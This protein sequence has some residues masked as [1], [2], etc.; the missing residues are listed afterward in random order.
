VAEIANTFSTFEAIGLR[1]ELADT[2]ANISPEDTPYQANSKRGSVDREL[3]DWQRD[4]LAAAVS[5]N[6]VEQ[7]DDITSFDAVTPTV[8]MRNHT[9]ISR[10]TL[11][12]AG[13]E[14]VVNKA[15]RA[16]EWAY[17]IVKKSAEMKR[18]IEKMVLENIAA[19][20]ASAGVAPK[21]AGLGAMVG[22][23]SGNNVSLGA[24][25]TNPTDAVN[26]TDPR[27]DGTARAFTEDFLKTVLQAVFTNGGNP[28]ILM[29]GPFN[30]GV[31]SGF[32]GVATK[33]YNQSMPKPA[34]IIGAA[35]IYVSNFGVLSVIP[36]RFQRERDAWVLDFDY[37]ELV[38]LRPYFTKDLAVTGDA[39][40]GALLVEWG[41]RV[42][43]EHALGLVAD[44]TTS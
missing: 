42:W 10:K 22:S 40:K 32:A 6:A 3:F 38:Y 8:R 12:I 9:Q 14:E 23:I 19:V 44:L 36:N 20:P 15:G 4:S 13:T 11:I 30:K 7:G 43:T 33:T 1:E 18:D 31:V 26:F 34:A 37:T 29:V 2:I 27:N 5:T 39:R 21:T 35:D 25:G 17:Q 24:T 28:K 41:H 16:S